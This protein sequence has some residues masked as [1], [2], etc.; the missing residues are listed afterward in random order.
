M[1]RVLATETRA[2]LALWGATS[3]VLSDNAALIE[4]AEDRYAMTC[5]TAIRRAIESGD[6]DIDPMDEPTAAARPRLRC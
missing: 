6:H 2:I 5:R 1:V 3:G 4:R